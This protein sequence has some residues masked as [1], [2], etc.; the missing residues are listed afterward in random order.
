[1]DRRARIEA[2][3]REVLD[4]TYVLVLDESDQHAGHAGARGGGGHFRAVVVSER[5][6]EKSPVERQQIVFAALAEEMGRDIHALSMQTLTPAQ[7]GE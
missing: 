2:K 6:S 3:L 7:W 4:A 1:M 5:F